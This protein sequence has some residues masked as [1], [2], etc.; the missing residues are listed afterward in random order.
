MIALEEALQIIAEK[1]E[2]NVN[3]DLCD[4]PNQ[5]TFGIFNPYHGVKEEIRLCCLFAELRQMWPQHFR[6]TVQEPAEWAGE[7]DMPASIW[8]RQLANHL[9][10]SVSDARALGMDPPKG[11]PIPEKARL[12]LPTGDGEYAEFVLG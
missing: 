11:K 12:Y 4:C 5:R 7:T 8:H 3:D 2:W 9:G 10:V 1:E 6:T